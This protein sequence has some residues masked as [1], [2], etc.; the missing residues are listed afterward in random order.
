MMEG[1]RGDSIVCMTRLAGF[2]KPA[3]AAG[4]RL[5]IHEEPKTSYFF[6]IRTSSGQFQNERS[7]RDQ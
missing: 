3:Q 1:V 5:H 4:E 6:E 7:A 2:I